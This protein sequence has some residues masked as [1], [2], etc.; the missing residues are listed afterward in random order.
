[1]HSDVLVLEPRSGGCVP[2]HRASAHRETPDAYEVDDAVERGDAGPK[3]IASLLAPGG[4]GE[5]MPALG[6]T[7]SNHIATAARLH[8]R[9]KAMSSLSAFI[10]GLIRTLHDDLLR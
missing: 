6:P 10:M 9:E 8:A 7:V 4:N 1:M 2:C 3:A 5:A